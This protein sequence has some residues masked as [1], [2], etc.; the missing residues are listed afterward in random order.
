MIKV[1]NLTKKYVIDKKEITILDDI[2]IDFAK[3]EIIVILGESGSGKTTFLNIISSLDSDY[4]GKVLIDNKD[5]KK[6]NKKDL[7]LYRNKKVGFVFQNF[8][9]IDHFT[10]LDNVLLPGYITNKNKI[11]KAK[12]LLYYFGL[13]DKINKKP[14]QL[15]GGEKQRVAIARALINDPDIIICD[16]P[17]GALDSKNSKDI[18]SI[19]KG[20]KEQG[21]LV[22]I[23]THSKEVTSI[24][25]KVISIKDGK[26]ATKVVNNEKN[27]SQKCFKYKKMNVLSCLKISLRNVRNKL[28]RNIL[29]ALATSFGIACV[30]LMLTI[31]RSCKNWIKE[32]QSN[33]YNPNIIEISKKNNDIFIEK[34][35]NKIK[36]INGVKSINRGTSIVS[37]NTNKIVLNKKD[38]YI[39]YIETLSINKNTKELVKGTFSLLGEALINE[40]LSKHIK[41][42]SNINLWIY[43]EE[44]ILKLNFKISGIYKDNLK[45]GNY[46]A[47][48]I[49]YDYLKNEFNKNNY[50]LFP[51]ILYLGIDQNNYIDVKNEVLS[52]DYNTSYQ[53]Y[54]IDL[55][56]KILDISTYILIAISGISLLVSMIMIFTIFYINV[57]ERSKEI[58]LLK[59]LGATN[60]SIRKIFWGESL[61]IALL[62]FLIATIIVIIGIIL[63]NSILNYYLF[64]SLI[65]INYNYLFFGL[66]LSIIITSISCLYPSYKAS[67]V[68]PVISLNK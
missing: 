47:V 8:N 33:F 21:K 5:L 49:D 14:N 4:G 28:Y 53:D 59:S 19:L 15:S 11:K 26:I 42:G 57:I 31:S 44:E 27:F 56:N 67:I 35:F 1:K 45:T 23:V 25:D 39:D 9:L 3:N 13:N 64:E 40:T 60:K 2:S 58:G 10:A 32:I 52:L 48:Y 61:I 34:D 29:I 18:L 16:E 37:M 30:I 6:Y 22:I 68:D 66:I 24:A 51:N 41:I 12:E 7:S 46:N 17:T 43:V 65:K 50:E 36:L 55:L 62:S 63:L 54:I 20:F 38:I